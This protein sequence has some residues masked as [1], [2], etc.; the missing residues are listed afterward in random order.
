MYPP[1]KTGGFIAPSSY[2]FS[3]NDAGMFPLPSTSIYR[4]EE[5]ADTTVSQVLPKKNSSGNP[6]GDVR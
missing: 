5:A 1:V 4:H 2:P 6:F 3:L